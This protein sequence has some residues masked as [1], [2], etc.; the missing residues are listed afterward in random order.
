MARVLW[1]SAR[2]TTTAAQWAE[3][4]AQ[5]RYPVWWTGDGVSLEASVH[6][7]VDSGVHDLKPYVHSD[8]GGDY[9]GSAGDLLRWTAH[10]TFGTMSRPSSP[11]PPDTMLRA[12]AHLG[13]APRAV[14]LPLP[15][16]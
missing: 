15:R 7:M 10:C 3:H 9:R 11:E 8:C 2:P 12:S 14:Q 13:F 16:Q 4:P 6:T 5:H 1:H